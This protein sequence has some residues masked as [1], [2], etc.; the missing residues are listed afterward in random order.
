M[1][2]L[3]WREIKTTCRPC[4]SLHCLV[5]SLTACLE[6]LG[7]ASWQIIIFLP[8]IEYASTLGNFT[9]GFMAQGECPYLLQLS[10]VS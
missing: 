10:P 1:R 6:S 3:A 4:N 7:K 9:E 8:F 2:Y 5:V